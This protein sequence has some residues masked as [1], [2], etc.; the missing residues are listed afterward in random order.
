LGR[1]GFQDFRIVGTGA[2]S[3]AQIAEDAALIVEVTGNLGRQVWANR[4]AARWR[5][6]EVL[7]LAS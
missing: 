6:E 5:H 1:I 4:A 2:P 7:W 3:L